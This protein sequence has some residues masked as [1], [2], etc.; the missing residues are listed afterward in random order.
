MRNL[1]RSPLPRY[2]HSSRPLPRKWPSCWTPIP[3][4]SVKTM[5]S[6]NSAATASWPCSS[7]QSSRT[8]AGSPLPATFS[9]PAHSATS[10]APSPQP[11]ALAVPTTLRQSPS[12]PSNHPPTWEPSPPSAS[13]PNTSPTPPTVFSHKACYS[14]C[15]NP[16]VDTDRH[17]STP[18]WPGTPHSAPASPTPASVKPWPRASRTSIPRPPHSQVTRP[19]RI[20]RS[21]VTA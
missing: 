20:W 13:P 12:H 5:T 4:A 9:T 6:W 15:L 18:W 11:M 10:P 19:L 8:A 3:E 2:R 7:S 14:P 1:Q 17:L 21:Y 16:S